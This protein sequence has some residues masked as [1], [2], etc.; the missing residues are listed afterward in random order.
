MLRHMEVVNFRDQ[1]AV[2][3]KVSLQAPLATASIVAQAILAGILSRSPRKP[4]FDAV[5]EKK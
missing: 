4:D 2:P 5:R 1:G 3:W